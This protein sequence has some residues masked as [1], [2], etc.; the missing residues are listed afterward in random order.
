MTN[1]FPVGYNNL[2]GIFNVQY[3]NLLVPGTVISEQVL[4]IRG[5]ISDPDVTLRYSLN[6]Y[7]RKCRR[8]YDTFTT[9]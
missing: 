8:I 9:E 2:Q 5:L 4:D 3:G 6:E 7:M 1:K